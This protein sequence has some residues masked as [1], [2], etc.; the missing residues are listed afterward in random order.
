MGSGFNTPQ[1][2]IQAI[3]KFAQVALK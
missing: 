3:K 1:E 2:H